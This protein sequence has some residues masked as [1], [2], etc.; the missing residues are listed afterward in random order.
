[1]SEENKKHLITCTF[2]SYPE[3]LLHCVGY[4]SKNYIKEDITAAGEI[5]P[6]EMTHCQY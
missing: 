3:K 6:V 5:T 2:L 1:M 4:F